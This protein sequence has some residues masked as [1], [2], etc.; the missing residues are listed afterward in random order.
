MEFSIEEFDLILNALMEYS[1]QETGTLFNKIF[2]ERER[3]TS[4]TDDC[5]SRG[6]ASYPVNDDETLPELVRSIS[7]IEEIDYI[8]GKVLILVNAY[9]FSPEQKKR[10]LAYKNKNRK[11]IIYFK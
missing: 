1:A 7:A 5:Y 10:L 2:S 8:R 11:V 3:I 9:K 6:E 4:G